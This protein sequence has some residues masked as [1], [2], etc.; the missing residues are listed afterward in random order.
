M[1][2][3]AAQS[4]FTQGDSQPPL[5]AAGDII[6]T[7]CWIRII[8]KILVELMIRGRGARAGELLKAAQSRYSQAAAQLPQECG[9]GY[10]S[11]RVLD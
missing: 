7:E 5:I 3:K 1:T 10:H 9:R 6:L 2:R 11:H 4:R 8:T